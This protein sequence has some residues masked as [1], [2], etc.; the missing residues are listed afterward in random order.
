MAEFLH[1]NLHMKSWLNS[2]ISNYSLFSFKF[3]SVKEN[4]LL[5]QSN[6]HPFF[7]VSSMQALRLLCQW[8]GCSV[9]TRQSCCY[10]TL[11]VLL[12]TEQGGCGGPCKR[13]MDVTGVKI[14]W[15]CL[16]AGKETLETFKLRDYQRDQPQGHNPNQA[17][18]FSEGFQAGEG[19]R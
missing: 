6:H 4:V 1:M 16:L 13:M 5:V 10:F 14:C 19:R 15:A 3:V 7:A 2:L 11:G 9:A 8:Y 12:T 18:R 17:I